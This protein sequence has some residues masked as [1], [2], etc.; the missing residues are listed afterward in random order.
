MNKSALRRQLKSARNAYTPAARRQAAR[1]SL[2][3]ALR[4]GLLLRARRIGVY[5]PHG[6]EFD[7]QLLISQIQLM[8]RECYAPVLPQRGRVL[9][10]ARIQR[11][12]P[13]T[14]N[15]FGIAEPVDARPL[16][17]RQL[18]LLLLPLVGF[19]QQGF[20]LGMGGGFYDATLAFMRHRRSWRKP[21]LV[22]LAYECQRVES[23]PHDP[24]DMPL[25]A[26]LTER[27]LYRFR[28]REAL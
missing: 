6:G 9:R 19:D 1:A 3:L 5:L 26:V 21:R 17:A 11:N 22:G 2:R 15:R 8:R 24:W 7:A 28:S 12:T 16:R 25:D 10:F 27:G 14:R 4:H 23:L 18:D 20:R 13:M